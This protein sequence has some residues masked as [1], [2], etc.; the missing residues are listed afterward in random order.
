LNRPNSSARVIAPV[1]GRAHSTTPNATEISPAR[2]NSARVPAGSPLA[3]AAAI[4]A[5]PA[6][7][8]QMP[9]ISTSTSA[10]GPGHARAI[11]PEARSTS[12]SSRC[13]NTGP[14]VRLLNAR[15]ACRPAAMNAHTA[16]TMTSARTVTWGQASEMIPTATASRPRRIRDALVS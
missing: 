14:A 16:N 13:P 4:S 11:T 12:P 6:M 9:T 15:M 1:C 10:V 8:A 7:T 5:T 3:K 2:M